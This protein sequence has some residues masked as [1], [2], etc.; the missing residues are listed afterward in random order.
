MIQTFINDFSV[1]A[2]FLP[3]S[4]SLELVL[5]QELC[6]LN[7][8]FSQLNF[9]SWTLFRLKWKTH[10]HTNTLMVFESVGKLLFQTVLYTQVHAKVSP[11][12]HF[13]VCLYM[14]LSEI[15]LFGNQAALHLL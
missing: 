13:M 7:G 9:S 6:A 3:I 12:S 10:F 5:F 8:Q 2:I 4:H 11:K 1:A 15:D 14:Q